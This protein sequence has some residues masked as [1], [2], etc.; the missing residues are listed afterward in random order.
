MPIEHT[1][2]RVGDLPTRLEDGFVGVAEVTGVVVPASEFR[3]NSNG[4][5]RPALE[6]LTAGHYHRD[7]SPEKQEHFVPVEWIKTVPLSE[8]VLEVGMFGN[9]NS[10]CKPTS[11]KWSYTVNRLKELWGIGE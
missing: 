7:A 3:I 4:S 2:W 9:Q 11:P 10:V 8:A 5:L 6:V 1:I